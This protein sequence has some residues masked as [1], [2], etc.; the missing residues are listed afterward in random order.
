MPEATTVQTDKSPQEAPPTTSAPEQIDPFRT[1]ASEIRKQLMVWGK[2]QTPG[3][4]GAWRQMRDTLGPMMFDLA[5]NQIATND[6]VSQSLYSLHA[7]FDE[8]LNAIEEGVGGGLS[9]A[10]ADKLLSYIA[11][12]QAVLEEAIG[13]SGQPEDVKKQLQALKEM[14][15]DC[16]NIIADN[17]VSEDEDG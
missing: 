13:A 7:E 4:D 15:D 5:M 9:A 14:G 2:M 17:V 1:L 11:G 8:R 3:V 6:W 12:T 10:E 16:L